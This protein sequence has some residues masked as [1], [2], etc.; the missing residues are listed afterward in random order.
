MLLS[1]S[2]LIVD[3]PFVAD[4]FFE[5]MSFENLESSIVVRFFYFATD[6]QGY[7]FDLESILLEK[8]ILQTSIRDSL[9]GV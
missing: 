3:N 2:K 9:L 7:L 6:H 5:N 1:T 8:L 4:N